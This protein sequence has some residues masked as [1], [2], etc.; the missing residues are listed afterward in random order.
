MLNLTCFFSFCCENARNTIHIHTHSTSALVRLRPPGRKGSGVRNVLGQ[1]Q[2]AGRRKWRVPHGGRPHH[3]AKVRKARV[4][5]V[6]TRQLEPDA[7]IGVQHGRAARVWV[8]DV[9]QLLR[10]L[11]GLT[12]AAH[13][14]LCKDL[15]HLWVVVQPHFFCS[16]L[17]LFCLFV[18]FRCCPCILFFNHALLSRVAHSCIS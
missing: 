7:S 13:A 1:A 14:K 5:W 4:L 12:P 9:R 2:V 3:L 15:S 10:A 11:L 16:F 17:Q 6:A 8:I 18:C